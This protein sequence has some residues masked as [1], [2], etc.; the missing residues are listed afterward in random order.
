MIKLG[1]GQ[2]RTS[3]VHY[4]WWCLKRK[5]SLMYQLYLWSSHVLLNHWST[6]FPEQGQR[7]STCVTHHLATSGNWLEPVNL[8]VQLVSGST[9]DS[10]R[11]EHT[12]WTSAGSFAQSSMSMHSR[13]EAFHQWMVEREG[14]GRFTWDLRPSKLFPQQPTNTSNNLKPTSQ[15]RFL[16]CLYRIEIEHLRRR[17][18]TVFK[19]T[20]MRLMHHRIGC[21]LLVA[22]QCSLQSLLSEFWLRVCSY[23]CVCVCL[24][25]LLTMHILAY[26]SMPGRKHRNNRVRWGIGACEKRVGHICI[27]MYIQ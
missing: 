26:P 12:S 8:Q 3:A 10:G 27:C 23:L 17:K 20:F 22:S 4:F 24:Y 13:N 18:T 11:G 7:W 5:T 2:Q 19:A 14:S 21:E 1:P 9:P 16:S 25:C 6:C 15:L